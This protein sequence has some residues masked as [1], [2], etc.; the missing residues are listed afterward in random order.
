MTQHLWEVRAFYTEEVIPPKKPGGLC[1]HTWN[2]SD[3]SKDVEVE[4]FLGRDDIGRVEIRHNG[5]PW[6]PATLR[7]DHVALPRQSPTL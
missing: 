6:K 7:P 1:L 2:D 3:W 4:T 5:G